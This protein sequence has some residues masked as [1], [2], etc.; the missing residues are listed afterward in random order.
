M[1]DENQRRAALAL[2]GEQQID[3][4]PAGRLV[5]IAGRLVGDQD[6]RVRARA[7]GRSRR[8]AARR[9]RAAPD[10]GRRRSPRPTLASSRLGALEG[11]GDAGKLERHR[12]VLERRHGR[13]QVEGLEDDADIAAAKA[14]E[15]VL[16]EA[17]QIARRPTATEPV[18][19]RSSP[20]M[21]ISSVDLP[22]PDGPTRPTASP[23]PI[24]RLDVLE[25]MDARR[26]APSV[27]LTPG[28]A[29]AGPSVKILVSALR[30]MFFRG[31]LLVRRIIGIA[32]R[33]GNR[34]QRG[35]V[36]A[37]MGR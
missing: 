29:I 7:R 2:A 26:A 10:N 9:R 8:A 3:D 21:T 17:G 30:V 1:G 34:G 4:L 24:S 6:R 20:A 13:D 32:G 16:V 33:Y 12:D 25:D 14:R 28:S 11:V 23:L 15:R 36:L 5:E 19:A 27:R 31:R 35:A 22:E 37:D 18:S